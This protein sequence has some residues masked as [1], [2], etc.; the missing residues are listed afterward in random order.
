MSSN[1]KGRLQKLLLKWRIGRPVWYSHQ[2]HK[3]FWKPR[4][5]NRLRNLGKLSKKLEYADGWTR[6]QSQ[7]QKEKQSISNPQWKPH[8]ELQSAYGH[9]P[10]LHL[11]VDLLRQLISPYYSSFVP[12]T[13]QTENN[14]SRVH[15]PITKQSSVVNYSVWSGSERH[16][17]SRHQHKKWIRWSDKSAS[18]YQI[19][20]CDRLHRVMCIE[21]HTHNTRC[22]HQTILIPKTWH[23][24]ASIPLSPSRHPL[25]TAKHFS[26][27]QIVLTAQTRIWKQIRVWFRCGLYEKSLIITG[28]TI[29]RL[30][31]PD[32]SK[33][34][35]ISQW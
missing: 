22:V 15:C 35:E 30:S 21:T 11:P 34:R 31:E 24:P 27:L 28:F 3:D 8:Q 1:L 13:N 7:Q 16:E 29:Q 32:T 33:Y 12:P 25:R 2:C 10:C 20:H 18:T 23:R 6:N 9:A 19:I 4:A 17:V 14:Y 26:T 5:R